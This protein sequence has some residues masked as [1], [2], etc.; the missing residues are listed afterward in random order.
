MAKSAGMTGRARV[1][2]MGTPDFACPILETL[3][4]NTNVIMV[5]TQPDK[6]VGRKKEIKYSPIKELALKNN[7]PVFES[8][9][10]CLIFCRFVES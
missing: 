2:F 1:I 9:G 6:E 5:V 10:I 7:I 4:K 8:L 3:I